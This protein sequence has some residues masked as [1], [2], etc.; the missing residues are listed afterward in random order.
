[1]VLIVKSGDSPELYVSVT[2]GTNINYQ[3]FYYNTKINGATNSS[4]TINNINVNQQGNYYCLIKDGIYSIN[5]P[6]T[7]IIVQ[8]KLEI[9]NQPLS[10][11]KTQGS[12][13][14]FKVVLDGNGPFIYQCN[15]KTN[16][17]ILCSK[18]QTT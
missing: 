11:S 17:L 12:Y 6:V 4:Y 14:A 10:Y 8:Q 9:I 13:A 7:T 3:W 1:M 18:N 2:G 15:Y 16:L 5:G